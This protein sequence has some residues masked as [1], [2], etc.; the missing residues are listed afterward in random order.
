MEI[1]CEQP[2]DVL[3]SSAIFACA[4]ENGNPTN[5]CTV[6]LNQRLKI[7]GPS[8]FEENDCVVS[9]MPYYEKTCCY[10]AFENVTLEDGILGYDVKECTMAFNGEICNSCKAVQTST[11]Y[12]YPDGTC[13][14]F[15]RLCNEFD[16]TN[17][18][19]GKSLFFKILYHFRLTVDL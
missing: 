11:E 19:Q 4:A 17:T 12:C 3:C 16:C 14:N 9:S 8:T 18:A 7:T 15:T 5:S 13:I 1:V 10:Y 2:L 6:E